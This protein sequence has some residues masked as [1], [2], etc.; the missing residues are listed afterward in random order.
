MISRKGRA[1]LGA[2]LLPLAALA[3]FG[4]SR[5]EASSGTS[6]VAKVVGESSS[7]PA[8]KPSHAS[9][10]SKSPARPSDLKVDPY[11]Y[12]IGIEDELSISVWREPELSGSVVVRPD[13]KITLPLI[14]DIPVTGLKTTELQ[15]L[16]TEKLKTFVNEPQVTVIVKAIRS[17]KV[18]LMGQVN[19]QGPYLLT[20]R[21]TALGLIA[22]AG[23]LGTFA[24]SNSIYILRKVG[25]KQVRIPFRYKKALAGERNADV[26]L[27]PGDIVVVP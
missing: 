7:Q 12:E 6:Q 5:P 15:S 16:L 13:G 17:R 21:K 18:Y 1:G 9:P 3:A 4:Q 19:K 8:K 14:N 24:K 2:A 20:A 23:G 22:E 27:Y 11:A 26:E 10:A 25:D